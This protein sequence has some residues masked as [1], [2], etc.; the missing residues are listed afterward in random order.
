MSTLFLMRQ[1]SIDPKVRAKI[2]AALQTLIERRGSRA[3]VA[4][5][6][7]MHGS[8]ISEVLNRGRAPRIESLIAMREGL[9]WSLDEICGLE[10]MHRE[11]ERYLAKQK[12]EPAGARA[13]TPTQGNSLP[14]AEEAMTRPS[15]RPV[16][17]HPAKRKRTAR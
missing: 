12:K 6:C 4:E 14:L 16:A 10:P 1:D 3:A 8:Q 2:A 17:A 13:V 15:V 9:G 11:A 5:E 7:D